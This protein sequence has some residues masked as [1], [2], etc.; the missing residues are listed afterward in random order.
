[1]SSKLKARAGRKGPVDLNWV[2]KYLK[3]GLYPPGLN[4]SEKRMVRKRAERFCFLKEKL[5]YVGT[6]SDQNLGKQTRLVLLT[7]EERWNAVANAHVDPEGT[8]RGLE[9]TV[10]AISAQYHWN[11]IYSFIKDYIRQCPVCIERHPNMLAPSG[12]TSQETITGEVDSNGMVEEIVVQYVEEVGSSAANIRE[13]IPP[14]L[15]DLSLFG[16]FDHSGSQK[17]VLVGSGSQT[18]WLEAF[19]LEEVTT[20]VLI[21]HIQDM[22]VKYGEIKQVSA[23]EGNKTLLPVLL[24]ALWALK[25]ESGLDINLM[26]IDHTESKLLNEAKSF[27]EAFIRKNPDLWPDKIDFCL[28]PLRLAQQHPSASSLA[29]KKTER[30]SDEGKAAEALMSVRRA[31]MSSAAE[32]TPPTKVST[33]TTPTYTGSGIITR[34]R[35]GITKPKTLD[36]DSYETPAKRRMGGPPSTDNSARKQ[37]R[38]EVV[39]LDSTTI[40][41]DTPSN[42]AST[43]EEESSDTDTSAMNVQ[44]ESTGKTVDLDTYYEAIKLYIDSNS[45]P[46]GSSRN[47]KR[48][49][50][51]QAK[52]Y[53]SHNDNLYH[54]IGGRGQQKKIIMKKEDRH[55]L[56]RDAHLKMGKATMASQLESVHWKG[57]MLDCE[58]FVLACPH[59]DKHPASIVRDASLRNLLDATKQ[60]QLDREDNYTEI[61]NHLI[62]EVFSDESVALRLEPIKRQ[63]K[64]F[65]IQDGELWHCLGNK[66]QHVLQTSAERMS[67][68]AEA[69]V[70]KGTHSDF[71]ATYHHL[72]HMFWFGMKLDVKVYTSLCCVNENRQLLE[73]YFNFR[74]YHMNNPPEDNVEPQAQEALSSSEQ[75]G[76]LE[77][78]LP[79]QHSP[80]DEP[81]MEETTVEEVSAQEL[82]DIVADGTQV[83]AV[84][85]RMQFQ[86]SAINTTVVSSSI[87]MDTATSQQLN[88]G[89]VSMETESSGEIMGPNHGE[90]MSM[91]SVVT[92]T[93]DAGGGYMETGE[94]TVEVNT[95]EMPK[96]TQKPSC[97]VVRLT[98]DGHTVIVNE[99]GTETVARQ[100]GQM[101]STN[102]STS[103]S[104]SV[105]LAAVKSIL[106][107]A[108]A[109]ESH[110]YVVDTSTISMS[111][112]IPSTDP[113]ADHMEYI[114]TGATQ[115]ED[116]EESDEWIY[117]TDEDEEL[118]GE[119]GYEDYSV[120]GGA[121]DG[122]RSPE[123]K[124]V[125]PR[126]H[127][128]CSQCNK[129]FYGPL[130]FKM[131]MYKHTG[132]KPFPCN[133]CHK[134]YTN[135]KS[136]VIHQRS[137]TG[138]LPYLCSLCG[139]RCP[140]KVALKSHLKCHDGQGGGF[141]AECDICHRMFSRK[142]LMERHRLHK[143]LNQ[144]TEFKCTECS[145]VF[146]HQRSLRRHFMSAHL[147]VKNHVCG[148]CGKS[149][150]RK[151]YLTGHLIQ[152]G[153]AVAEGL[154]NRKSRT[155][156]KP[157]PS[158]FNQD[159]VVLAQKGDGDSSENQEGHGD[160][161][162]HQQVQRI[163]LHQ[164]E[165]GQLRVVDMAT[166]QEVTRMLDAQGIR[167]GKAGE[168]MV[169]KIEEPRGEPQVVHVQKVGGEL[170]EVPVEYQPI[171][172]DSI[173]GQ[174]TD[175]S[176]HYI[177]TSTPSGELSVHTSIGDVTSLPMGP[178]DPGDGGQE[179][180]YGQP[181][182]QYEVECVGDVGD[183]EALSAINLLAQASA[184]Q[185]ENV[186]SQI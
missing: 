95:S 60:L 81:S 116:G 178:E 184:Q 171:D 65:R 86:A 185:Y 56:L 130:K 93:G 22:I 92:E 82:V 79:A 88:S 71:N 113:Q 147:N 29:N 30:E 126:Q 105:T 167:E 36:H 180:V 52:N 91:T 96:L 169:V 159:S 27:I 48:L 70:R 98:P 94:A 123:K 157:R 33:V 78:T 175:V 49:I 25:E 112:Q 84:Q 183:E 140:S 104:D 32:L 87:E 152:H 66:L 53:S 18:A 170:I 54:K 151:E 51:D 90:T 75:H 174:N 63:L 141:P 55:Q 142:H 137:H 125:T 138:E 8:H 108:G 37:A 26:K 76:S 39:T 14:D 176:E 38:V 150:Y 148:L 73:R 179:L 162:E 21:Q 177:Y 85:D 45:Y 6:P 59:C 103:N 129:I 114:A 163:I 23:S 165:N 139:R 99:D 149:F 46:K 155:C 143:H 62:Y 121:E 7:E 164:D 124:I 97:V 1:M 153:G 131:H 158:V 67:A 4:F 122:D 109:L 15:V 64:N 132:Q 181:A 74:E 161:L 3:D 58:A 44:I 34:G 42:Q 154:A 117:D 43:Y 80:G 128:K 107:D 100:A 40:S 145:K 20:E 120:T 11:A 16:P 135:K 89:M 47:F 166:E 133:Q 69:H 172:T 106:Q 115:T 77:S 57:K 12:R 10:E 83:S 156:Y 19:V 68:I 9:R 134:K 173:S 28:L 110:E 168:T 144:Q 127:F 72:S 2:L 118:E 31:A 111:T 182:V 119:T 102:P 13:Q 35:R 17:F 50:R 24:S 160:L 146:G 101:I 186:I 41:Q 61:S 136:L 5:Y